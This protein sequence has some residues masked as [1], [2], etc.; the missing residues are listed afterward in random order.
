MLAAYC[1]QL[2]AYGQGRTRRLTLR[3]WL[4][5]MKSTLESR[6]PY[7]DNCRGGI[8]PVPGP[9]LQWG[10]MLGRR[11]KLL[12]AASNLVRDED[13][14]AAACL[15]HVLDD[16]AR[17]APIG[18]AV[19]ALVQ[20]FIVQTAQRHAYILALHGC[21]DALAQTGLSYARRGRRGQRIGLRPPPF[22]VLLRREFRI[23][24][25]SFSMPCSGRSFRIRLA[26]VRLWSSW[27]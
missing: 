15:Q 12:C 5:Q 24:A 21:C 16:A 2:H 14:I 11:L 27:V 26:Q 18:A 23:L 4:W 7:Q 20:R 9:A 3:C 13:R 17:Q 8:V 22:Q 19:T 25:P 1:Y 6:N 10:L